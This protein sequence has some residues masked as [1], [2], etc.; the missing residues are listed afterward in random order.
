VRWGIGLAILTVVA[1]QV[2]AGPFL[3]GLR[4]IDPAVA[5]AALGIGVV[6]TVAAAVRWTFVARGLGVPIPLGRSVIA[7][8]R[9]QFL[10]STLPGGVLGD[11]HRG[12]VH[13]RDADDLGTALRA[14][15]WERIVGQIVQAVLAL[16]VVVVLPSPIGPALPAAAVAATVVL[17]LG[18][19][20]VT[21]WSAGG[22]S[23]WARIVRAVRLDFHRA[24]GDRRA[25]GLVVASSVVVVIGHAATFVIAARVAGVDG[26]L[27]RLLPLA[28]LVLLAM[29]VPT[30]VGGWGPREGVTAA[31]FAAAGLGADSGITTA[32]VYGVMALLATTPGL[33]VLVAGAARTRTRSRVSQNP[34]GKAAVHV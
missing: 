4:R 31:L 21:A 22:P 28:V 9:A 8:Y 14:V 25:A 16:A 30:N 23:R 3:A 24:L 29:A 6:T 7:Y 15:A 2:G 32:T 20:L 10:N 17:I 34:N 19:G 13:G 26:S 1:W 27:T 18:G 12:I 33:L 11:V 5:V